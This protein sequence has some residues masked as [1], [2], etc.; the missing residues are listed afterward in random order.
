MAVNMVSA[1][2]VIHI[3]DDN[4]LDAPDLLLHPPNSIKGELTYGE[5]YS[6]N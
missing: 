1:D 3:D 2:L 4:V 5:F 6:H